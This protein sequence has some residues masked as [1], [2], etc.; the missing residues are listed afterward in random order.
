MRAPP[1]PL[2]PHGAA[3][4]SRRKRNSVPG[5]SENAGSTTCKIAPEAAFGATLT[6]GGRGASWSEKRSRH[7]L[8][9]RGSCRLPRGRPS[10]EQTR[11]SA[12]AP[13]PK[14]HAFHGPSLGV[15]SRS[16]EQKP[17]R[18]ALRWYGEVA[19]WLGSGLQN[20]HTP[21][22]IRSSPRLQ[23]LAGYRALAPW[24]NG[25]RRGLKIPSPQGRA[26]SSPAGATGSRRPT[27][28]GPARPGARSRSRKARGWRPSCSPRGA[29]P[30][31]CLEWARGRG[32]ASAPRRARFALG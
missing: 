20:R 10:P 11:H 25:R 28:G 18:R 19:K 26:G 9:A 14:A 16:S 13:H 3:R 31:S 21:V 32:C 15:S 24:R 2:P 6:D 5:F 1:R 4:P 29:G 12:R 22:R 27:P 8:G 7:E 23:P 17:K 30:S